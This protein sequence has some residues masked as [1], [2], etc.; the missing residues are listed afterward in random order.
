MIHFEDTIDTIEERQNSKIGKT[1]AL[2]TV[3]SA[4]C[5][6][7]RA[8][9]LTYDLVSRSEALFT[10]CTDDIATDSEKLLATLF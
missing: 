7:M 5:Q 3:Y 9:G 2:S 4:L 6:I 1:A 10:L 8:E